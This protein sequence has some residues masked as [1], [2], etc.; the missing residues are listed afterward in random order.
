MAIPLIYNS[1]LTEQ[2][3]DTGLIEREKYNKA[4]EE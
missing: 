2:S 1:S 4:C 3:F